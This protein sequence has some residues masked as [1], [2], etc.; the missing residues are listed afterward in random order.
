MFGGERRKFGFNLLSSSSSSS[1]RSNN[2]FSLVPKQQ[3]GRRKNKRQQRLFRHAFL[4]LLLLLVGFDGMKNCS[5]ALLRAGSASQGFFPFP[6]RFSG[7]KTLHSHKYTP[8]H[9][10][11]KEDNLIS[12][13][14]IFPTRYIWN[15][16]LI[17]TIKTLC[18]FEFFRHGIFLTFSTE[19]HRKKYIAYACAFAVS[20]MSAMNKNLL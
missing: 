6:L 14:R 17:I 2:S 8:A 7:M 12:L 13:Y 20:G 15:E 11:N 4:T 19:A 18:S 10:D 16:N 3:Q 5:R 9:A 1:P